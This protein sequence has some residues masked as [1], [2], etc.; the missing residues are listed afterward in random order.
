MTP[1]DVIEPADIRVLIEAFGA[2]FSRELGKLTTR[3]WLGFHIFERG[4]IA[5]RAGL[6]REECPYSRCR[7]ERIRVLWM[8]G[9]Y[10]G[11]E[12][13]ISDGV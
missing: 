6:G 10:Y 8:R 1:P 3:E 5:A 4:E 9:W 12:A 13:E 11:A 7:D 2:K